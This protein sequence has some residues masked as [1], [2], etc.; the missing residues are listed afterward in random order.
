MVNRHIAHAGPNLLVAQLKIVRL[1]D[2]VAHSQFNRGRRADNAPPTIVEPQGIGERL[3]L[4]LVF[5]AIDLAPRVYDGNTAAHLADQ[6][7]TRGLVDR[8]EQGLTVRQVGHDLVQAIVEHVG[9]I[10]GRQHLRAD[11]TA[12]GAGHVRH[13]ANGAG[14]FGVIQAQIESDGFG[15]I[16]VSTQS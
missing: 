13:L 10:L 15:I 6:G 12:V 7:Q 4:H 1:G 14:E 9:K 16:K 3:G 5:V 8:A 2:H 11:T